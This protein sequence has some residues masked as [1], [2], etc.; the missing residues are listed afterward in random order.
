MTCGLCGHE[1]RGGAKFCEEC[2]GRLSAPGET[3]RRLI[4]ALYCDMVGSTELGERLD[5]EL[6]RKLLDRYFD[7][8]RTAGLRHGGTVE[9]FVGDAVVAAFGVPEAHEDDALRAVR[10]AL[11]IQ[12]AAAKLDQEIDDPEVRSE[13]GR[14]GS[15]PA[16]NFSFPHMGKQA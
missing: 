9:K 2:G 7:A 12:E 15:A 4:T 6:L 14:P 11:E 16:R 13:V 8:M 5:T 3:R 1:N 10:A